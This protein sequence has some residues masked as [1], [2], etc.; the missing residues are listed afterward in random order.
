MNYEELF[1]KIDKWAHER[2]IDHAD[3][4]VEFM[5][6]AEELGELS[7]AYNKEHRGLTDCIANL[8]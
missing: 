5:K 2:G 4:R 1:Q 7:S 6:M 3:P 8:L